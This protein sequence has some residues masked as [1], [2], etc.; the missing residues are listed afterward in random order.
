M[1]A[2]RPDGRPGRVARG[3]AGDDRRVR[4]AVR[5]RPVDPRGRGAG[6]DREPVRPTV[7]HGNLT[8]AD[9]RLPPRDPR[10]HRLQAR[11]QLWLE[12]GPL[13]G[14]GAGGSRVRASVDVPTV[15]DV[16]GGLFQV[17]QR[18]T[19]E[20]EGNEKPVCWPRASA[21]RWSERQTQPSDSSPPRKAASFSA[22]RSIA[23][24]THGGAGRERFHLDAQPLAL[25]SQLQ[26][27]LDPAVHEQ[28]GRDPARLPV[29]T[30]LV[31]GDST[32]G[33]P[34][35]AL[36]THWPKP[37]TSRADRGSR[38][39]Q[40]MAGPPRAPGSA[41]TVHVHLDHLVAQRVEYPAGARRALETEPAGH[42]P[43][44]TRT[45][46]AEPGRGSRAVPR[47]VRRCSARPPTGPAM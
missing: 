23:V 15:D 19:I 10:V 46:C 14:A 47:P 17:T 11:C 28:G 40:P 1:G 39:P 4:R 31:G 29:D 25:H 13:S 12:Q 7:A 36:T 35:G 33:L 37:G 24:R 41:S 6:E 21:A 34:R 42:V 22:S 45:V 8:P 38:R 20:V 16:G 26:T 43:A 30:R 9:R 3:E 27:P 2:D 44:R 32:A 5:R 18:W